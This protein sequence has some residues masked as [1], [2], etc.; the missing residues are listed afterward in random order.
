V[1]SV[2]SILATR[3]VALVVKKS[4]FAPF[5]LEPVHAS[6]VGLE[7]ANGNGNHARLDDPCTDALAATDAN[8]DYA[9]ERKTPLPYCL[10]LLHRE[11]A[12]L[13]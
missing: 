12:N 13:G 2:S 7:D 4:F 5:I 10:H 1:V 8:V 9:L 11:G 3:F 6:K